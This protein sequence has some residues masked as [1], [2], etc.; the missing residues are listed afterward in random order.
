MKRSPMPSRKTPLRSKV[1][2]NPVNRKRRAKEQPR[3]FGDLAAFVRG[4]PCLVC[5]RTPS[6]AAHVKGR[7]NH[8][9]W[10]DNGDGNIAPLCADCHRLQHSIGIVSFQEKHGIDLAAEARAV[11]VRFHTGQP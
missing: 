5:K 9:A 10:L 8:G 2:V 6:Q 11:G 4:L 3:Q 1:R 7:R